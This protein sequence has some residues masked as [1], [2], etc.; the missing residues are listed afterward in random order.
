MND[1]RSV[2]EVVIAG[3][4]HGCGG[5]SYVCP[6]TAVI[7]RDRP[8]EGI[9]PAVDPSRCVLCGA[10]VDVCSGVAM[11][12]DRSQWQGVV[13]DLI[14]GWGPVLEVWEGYATDEQIRHRGSSGGV[15]TALA[16][17]CVEH[18]GMD[19]VLHIG[20]DPARPHLNR[21]QF[22]RSR[23]DLLESAGSRYS[24]A[25]PCAELHTIETAANPCVFVGKPCDVASTVRAQGLMPGLEARIGLM[26]AVFCAGTPSTKGTFNLLEALGVSKECV[27]DLRYRGF[28]WPGRTGVSLKNRPASERIEMDYRKAWHGILAPHRAFR[29]RICPDGTG[30]FAD[31]ACGDPWYRKS[32]LDE[33]GSSLIVVRTEKGRAALYQAMSK[34]AVFAERR[35]PNVLPLSQRFLHGRRRMVWA[36]FLAYRLVGLPPWRFEGFSLRKLWRGVSLWRSIQALSKALL[37]AFQVQWRAQKDD[38]T[39]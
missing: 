23:S 39:N 31:I 1:F 15:V 11:R 30:E 35:E 34:G 18:E 13:N 8:D 6:K 3:L 21:T 5:C 37:M 25:A 29:C 12:H 2:D 4:C 7:L 33:P 24:P 9:R 19:G 36:F 17:H 14:E 38:R 10:C 26:I 20:M 32:S 16:L 28:G 27:R 22:D